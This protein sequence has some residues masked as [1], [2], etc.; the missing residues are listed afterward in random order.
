MARRK[1]VRVSS[2]GQV[3]IPQDFRQ[4]MG[5][6]T[7]DE[8]VFHLV[9]DSV[10][11]AERAEPTEFEVA[12]DSLRAE[13]AAQDLTADD[14]ARALE[15]AQQE[16][17][18]EWHEQPRRASARDAALAAADW[19][20]DLRRALEQAVQVM[21]DLA[22]PQRILL[23]GSW[24]SGNARPD[25]DV[26]LLVVAETTSRMRLAAKL[27]QAVRPLLAPRAVDLIVCTPQ[28]WEKGRHLRGFVP[29]EAE[30]EGVELYVT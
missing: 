28:G 10:L 24:A 18:R 13:V 26:D 19:P 2:K 4:A 1:R 9:G 16:T 5:L 17:Y 23:F 7:G 11:V 14:I 25:S 22:H 27:L 15:E 29:H 6:Q 12:L 8:L 3:V 20:A 21:V 30:R